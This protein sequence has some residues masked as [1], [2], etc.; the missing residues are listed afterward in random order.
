MFNSIER[1]RQAIIEYNFRNRVEIK[2]ARN[3]KIRVRAHCAEN[4]SWNLYASYYSKGQ[5]FC[6][7]N[8]LWQ[9]QLPKRVVC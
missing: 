8:I 1:L 4:L 9:A 3:D 5:S 6:C 2:M 7:K